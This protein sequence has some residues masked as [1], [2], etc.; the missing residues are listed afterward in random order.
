[1]LQ[2]IDAEALQGVQV[3]LLD[4]LRRRFHDHL[5]LVVVLQPVGVFSV[6]AVGGTPRGLDVGHV[7]RFRAQRTQKGGR[8]EGAG[9]DLDVVGLLNHAALFRP[10]V[11]ERKNQFLKGHGASSRGSIGKKNPQV[12]FRKYP[13]KLQDC[14][15]PEC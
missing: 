10:V 15:F 8:I 12:L 13:G 7:P 2:G 5:V 4:V 1:M 6:A 11:V 9:P 3:D 14:P